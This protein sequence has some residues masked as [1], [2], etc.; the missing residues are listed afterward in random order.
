M[1]PIYF[2]KVEFV[3]YR[4]VGGWD[5]PFVYDEYSGVRG[6]ES[7][8]VLDLISAEL[9]YQVFAVYE[10]SPVITNDFGRKVGGIPKGVYFKQRELF[11][12]GYKLTPDELK[13][14]LPYCNALEY[15]AYR[16]KIMSTKDA[17]YRGY[18]DQ[19][20]MHFSAVTDSYIPKMNLPMDYLYDEEHTW[21]HER[22]YKYLVKR[23]LENNRELGEYGPTYG[24]GV[25]MW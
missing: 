9:F 22:L 11:S 7:T 2:S 6:K 8:L 4:N 16:G 13:E 18:R 20:S 5:E 24:A 14:V 19:V 3:G 12:Y 23:F 1:K 10:D 15:E 17:G 21:P 25:L